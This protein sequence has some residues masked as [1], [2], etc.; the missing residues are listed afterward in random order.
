MADTDVRMV[1]LEGVARLAKGSQPTAKWRGLWANAIAPFSPEEVRMWCRMQWEGILSPLRP[2]GW[3]ESKAVAAFWGIAP[4][5][6]HGTP[7]QLGEWAL[8]LH[9][10]DARAFAHAAIVALGQIASGDD[11][12]LA[13]EAIGQLQRLK[14]RI[15]HRTTAK[16]LATTL[17]SVAARRGLSAEALQDLVVEDAGLGP[18]GSRK[19]EAG[20]YDMY[21]FLSDDG[22]AELGV[23]ERAS[24]RALGAPPKAV[25]EGHFGVLA[26]VKAIQKVIGESLATQKQ[27][28]E[29]AL[30]S[31]RAWPAVA[32]RQVFGR[33]PIMR[34][35]ARRL[36]WAL[37][38]GTLAGFDG[39]A[40]V[41]LEGRHVTPPE[42]ATIHL[43]HPALLAPEALT[44]WQHHVVAKRLVQPFKQLFREV[45]R[46]TPE[47]LAVAAYSDRFAGMVVRHRQLYA[48]LRGRGWSGLA[49]IGP[50]GYQGTKELNGFGLEAMVGFHQ[51]R[52]YE[53]RARREVVL[54][55]L[56]FYPRPLPDWEPGVERRVA[57]AH[58]PAV[59]YSE[60][61][62]DLALVVGVAGV[63]HDD[64]PQRPPVF[65]GSVEMRASL[66]RELLPLLGLEGRVALEGPY[67]RVALGAQ[68]FRLHLGTG[69]VRLDP[70]DRPL[71]LEGLE[72]N[73]SPLYM[74]HE[75]GDSATAAIIATLVWLVQYAQHA[76]KR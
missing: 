29:Q 52:Y 75:G 14:G 30:E 58:V 38:D 35:L 15:R 5:A 71:D 47:D 59:A 43:A 36:V 18:D 62:R 63:G 24:G 32:W 56:E 3:L 53:D 69:E 20:P 16:Q 10:A 19:W 28:L 25:R 73:D 50:A 57:I 48:L 45:Y 61:M 64:S 40:L 17:Q 44:A 21:L 46:P 74:P 42:T 60:V 6:A 33:N 8:R 2:E 70:D 31:Q 1:V 37:D 22:D 41:D 12:G 54:E 72:R 23:F 11:A 76:Q 26:E 65:E 7:A 68:A 27:R 66:L 13:D 49:G 9:K 34:H 55:Q 51:H 67:A 4:V 39:Q